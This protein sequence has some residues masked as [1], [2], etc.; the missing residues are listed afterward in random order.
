MR[1]RGEDGKRS[2]VRPFALEGIGL[3]YNKDI[4]DKAG[5]DPS[6]LTN[7]N[8]YKE[9]FKKI[10]SM[11]D[12]LGLTSVC[13]VAAESGQMYWSTGNHM[14]AAYSFP[15]KSTERIRKLLTS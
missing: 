11:K 1:L 7:I 5:V 6:T 2:A 12:E 4:L 10:D 15:G 14:M 9:A 13:A 8:A 3:A